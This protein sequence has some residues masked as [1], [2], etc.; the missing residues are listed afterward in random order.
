MEKNRLSSGMSASIVEVTD[1]ATVVLA[2]GAFDQLIVSAGATEIL[3]SGT[4]LSDTTFSAIG[5][6][7]VNA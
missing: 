2:G 5:A 4:V 1:D 6:V 7:E 3:A